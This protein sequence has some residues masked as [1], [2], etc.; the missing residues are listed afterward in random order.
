MFSQCVTLLKGREGKE[1]KGREGREHQ[2]L[3]GN[4]SLSD[5]DRL[6]FLLIFDFWDSRREGKER[7]EGK[8]RQGREGKGRDRGVWW[9][10]S[11]IDT[12]V[13]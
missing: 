5:S 9:R 3:R 12:P 11:L 1:G 13:L 2:I 6:S 8:G 10:R 7:K 4:L